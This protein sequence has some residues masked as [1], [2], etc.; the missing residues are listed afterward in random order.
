MAK[1]N[2]IHNFHEEKILKLASEKAYKILGWEQIWNFEETIEKTILWYKS[3]NEGKSEYEC[4]LKDIE[5]F[6]SRSN[7]GM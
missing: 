7:Y 6:E 2:S 1:N 3:V 5:N 4:C